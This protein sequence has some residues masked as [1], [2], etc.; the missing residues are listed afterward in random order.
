MYCTYLWRSITFRSP[1]IQRLFLWLWIQCPFW[2][3]LRHFI[4]I[5]SLSHSLFNQMSYFHTKCTDLPQEGVTWFPK[6]LPRTRS[7]TDGR[8]LSLCKVWHAPLGMSAAKSCGGGEHFLCVIDSCQI[9]LGVSEAI[10][11]CS[12]LSCPS[13]SDELELNDRCWVFL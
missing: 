10:R 1:K 2:S 3:I 11:L 5:G 13:C 7:Q 8:R 12:W 4:F 6:Y 9:L